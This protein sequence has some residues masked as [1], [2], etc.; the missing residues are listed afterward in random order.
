MSPTSAP[1][2][3]QGI[4]YALLAYGA[5]GLFPI[6]WKGFG[7]IP[8]V[9][10]IAHRLVWSLVFLLI[11]VTATGRLRECLRIVRSPRLV[12]TLALTAALLSINWGLFVHGVNSGQVVEASLGYF[13]NP[14]LSV[15]LG[16]LILRERLTRLQ[17]IAVGL[18]SLGVFAFGYHVGRVPW[19]ALGIAL[20]F[21]LYGLIRKM[22][23]V[24]PL[25]GLV[26][27]T[28]VSAPI[29]AAVIGLHAAHGSGHFFDSPG[30]TLLFL[31]GGVVTAFP[32][33]WFISAAK[34]LPLSMVGFFQYL[35]P[36]L[37]LAVGVFLF[38]ERFT[39]RDAIAFG[40]IWAAIAIFLAGS[41]RRP[42]PL[43]ECEP[44]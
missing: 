10:V 40:L 13:F 29:A 21:G 3:R 4:L 9:E 2:S 26:V 6:Y 15:L 32:L 34:L 5:W 16:F 25:P 12:A 33:I 1:L 38:H 36:T 30:I 37:Q 22:V 14:L 17:V 7:A 42:R 28:G 11:L 8:P 39:P 41:R 18:A 35:A 19:I 31:G 44:I 24:D 23:P 20:S 43:E 27:E